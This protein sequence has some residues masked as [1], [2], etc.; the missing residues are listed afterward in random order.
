MVLD[1][2]LIYSSLRKTISPVVSIAS[3]SIVLCVGLRPSGLSL[4]HANMS[5]VWPLFSK[6]FGRDITSLLHR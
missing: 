2:Q 6:C 3:L 1:N 5:S 4:N